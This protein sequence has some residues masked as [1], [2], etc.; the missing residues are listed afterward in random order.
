MKVGVHIYFI[1]HTSFVWLVNMHN[2]ITYHSL[3]DTLQ[4][5]YSSF[6]K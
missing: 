2:F 3:P 4:K 6:G 5:A 1:P